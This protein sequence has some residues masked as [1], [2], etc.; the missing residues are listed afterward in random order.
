[1]NFVSPALPSPP[2][3]PCP[4][5]SQTSVLDVSQDL[6]PQTSSEPIPLEPSSADPEEV[7]H[8]LEV[9]QPMFSVAEQGTEGNVVDRVKQLIHDVDGTPNLTLLGPTT[10]VP[11]LTREQVCQ[12]MSAMPSD[13]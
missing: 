5:V 1:M 7:F 2:S 6:V 11:H 10:E 8:V 9:L 4:S 13:Y 12:A 3:T